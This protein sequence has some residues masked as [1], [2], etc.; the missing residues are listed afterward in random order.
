MKVFIVWSTII[1][2]ALAVLVGLIVVPTLYVQK[3]TCF[4]KF[5]SFETKWDYYSECQIKIQDKWIPADSYYFK[6]E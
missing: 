2:L 4:K 5:S 6:E 3:N 1:F